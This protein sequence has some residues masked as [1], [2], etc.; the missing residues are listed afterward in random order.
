MRYKIVI[1]PLMDQTLCIVSTAYDGQFDRSTHYERT[2]ALK[3]KGSDWD[4]PGL[5]RETADQLDAAQF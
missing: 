1:Y 3:T 4:L 2:L 5:L